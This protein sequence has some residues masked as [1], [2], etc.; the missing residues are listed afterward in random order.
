VAASIAVGC[1]TV[2]VSADWDQ[3]HDFSGYRTFGW[4]H[5]QQPETG[6]FR[7]DN[8]LVDKRIREAI[9]KT[10]QARGY[11]KV[12]DTGADFLV[13]YHL[14]VE[15]RL[16]VQTMNTY[17][18]YGRHGRWGGVGYPQTYVNEYEQ[19]S[20]VID[21][22]DTSRRELVWRGTG[23]RRVSQSSSPEKSSQVTDKAVAE[24]LA[25]FPPN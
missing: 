7:I 17:Y 10:L 9:D 6:D 20:L 12:G 21:V 24:I 13:G 5:A 3:N 18:G 25:R 22:A 15:K 2:S 16:D 11:E 14:D 23:T 8:P 4:L 1:R 19:G